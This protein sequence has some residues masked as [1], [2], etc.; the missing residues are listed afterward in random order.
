MGFLQGLTASKSVRKPRTFGVRCEMPMFYS[1]SMCLGWISLLS[2]PKVRKGI[3]SLSPIGRA[4]SSLLSLPSPAQ[5]VIKAFRRQGIGR[6][7]VF[8]MPAFSSP[9]LKAFPL[10]LRH[11]RSSGSAPSLPNLPRAGKGRLFVF[12]FVPAKESP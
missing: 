5:S 6:A 11:F 9:E 4:S 7:D 1:T 8:I 2:G 12:H 10:H 3:A